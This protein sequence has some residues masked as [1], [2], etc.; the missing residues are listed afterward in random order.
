MFLNTILLED[1]HV[2][3][4]TLL[5]LTAFVLQQQNGVVATE[6]VWPEKPK[7]FT[8]WYISEEDFLLYS[9]HV[10]NAYCLNYFKY[11]FE[12]PDRVIL[13]LKVFSACKMSG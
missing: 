11:K 4:S 8:I 6:T 12:F 5:S 2:H 7:I 13:I 1:S 10:G 9:R 3:S